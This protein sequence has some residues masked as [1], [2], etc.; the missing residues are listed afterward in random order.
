MRG[1]V[2]LFVIWGV[3]LTTVSV[4]VQR[5]FRFASKGKYRD[6]T[7]WSLVLLGV[8][9]VLTMLTF[10]SAPPGTLGERRWYQESPAAECLLFVAMLFGMAASYL[11][12][13]IERRRIRIEEKRKLSD[14]S[15]T[16]LEF[17]LWE[18]SYPML[19]S[20]I[21]FGAILQNIGEKPID[22][23]SMILSF[24]TGFFWQTVLARSAPK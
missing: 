4:I 8:V 2:L 5:I 23:A 7:L 6:V 18:F 13:Q 16:P 12:K 1:A 15:V 19:V 3:L 9:A 17:D 14:V 20:V 24:Q 11:T 21:T 10:V 22:L